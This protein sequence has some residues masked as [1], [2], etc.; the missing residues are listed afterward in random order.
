MQLDFFSF[1]HQNNQVAGLKSKQVARNLEI[2]VLVVFKPLY[3]KMD[4]P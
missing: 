2:V 4:L 3:L 1:K